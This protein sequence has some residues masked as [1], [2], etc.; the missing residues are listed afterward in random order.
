MR[1]T[2]KITKNTYSKYLE[3]LQKTYSKNTPLKG[4]YLFLE[5]WLSP[6][7]LR[8]SKNIIWSKEA[9]S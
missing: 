1:V 7:P 6:N 9:Q 8:Y 5:Y 2:P 3:L 4:G